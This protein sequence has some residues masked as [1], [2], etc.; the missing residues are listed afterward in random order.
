MMSR[1]FSSF[2][3]LFFCFVLA[4]PAV[5]SV[6][7]FLGY[8][9]DQESRHTKAEKE[10]YVAKQSRFSFSGEIKDDIVTVYVNESHTS[11]DKCMELR[12]QIEDYT[13]EELV[14]IPIGC[15]TKFDLPPRAV[16]CV[17]SGDGIIINLLE[18]RSYQGRAHWFKMGIGLSV[19]IKKTEP[20]RSHGDTSNCEMRRVKF[21]NSSRE[22]SLKSNSYT[23][24]ITPQ[25]LA[26]SCLKWQI[27][28][29]S[30]GPTHFS[31]EE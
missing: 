19:I 1:F 29:T 28:G 5:A 9:I 2:F 31:C 24:V 10:V 12:A 15:N 26:I 23:A 25:N 18:K 21:L 30:R 17:S 11:I 13:Q 8:P 27:S 7:I 6:E 4:S 3:V 20:R 14:G 22:V 16:D